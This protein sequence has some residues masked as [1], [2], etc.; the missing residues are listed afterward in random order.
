MCPWPLGVTKHT[1]NVGLII[2]EKLLGDW[3][4]RQYALE[5]YVFWV[6][7]FTWGMGRERLLEAVMRMQWGST[8][9][10]ISTMP[11]I[12]QSPSP[13]CPLPSAWR[14]VWKQRS[15]ALCEDGRS[16]WFLR[17]GRGSEGTGRQG[18]ASCRPCPGIWNGKQ[19]NQVCWLNGGGGQFWC[20]SMATHKS[21]LLPLWIQP[22]QEGQSVSVH[23]VGPQC[24]QE[25]ILHTMAWHLPEEEKMPSQ[26][27]REINSRERGSSTPRLCLAIVSPVG[28]NLA[29]G[30]KRL[31]SARSGTFQRPSLSGGRLMALLQ[32]RQ[33][34][35]RDFF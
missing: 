15:G 34:K 32:S 29:Q 18:W 21:Y 28:K 27:P 10:N 16:E 35:A 19:R 2:R 13:L 11:G 3:R 1:V 8:R 7:S 25:Q 17:N 22:T 30:I 4:I 31:L 12:V 6:L 24:C 33:R 20:Q 14:W 23:R 5:Q 9:K 26:S